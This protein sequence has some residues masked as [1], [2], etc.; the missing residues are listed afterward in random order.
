MLSSLLSHITFYQLLSQFFSKWRDK[1]YCGYLHLF[2]LTLPLSLSM[3][4][5]VYKC[6]VFMLK[7]YF[8]RDL[9]ALSLNMIS[10]TTNVLLG[11]LILGNSGE[12]V[13]NYGFS[14]A[15]RRRLNRQG[16]QQFPA[17]RRQDQVTLL[18]YVN[19]NSIWKLSAVFGQGPSRDIVQEKRMNL[20]HSGLEAIP[21]LTLSSIRIY[22]ITLFSLIF[23]LFPSFSWFILL[24]LCSSPLELTACF[25]AVSL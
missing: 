13:A 22:S 11:N 20:E 12:L 4:Q 24:K 9:R 5:Y 17:R 7:N 6:C 10:A 3:S 18:L 19:I 14:V 1:D 25:L 2:S 16:N 8:L 15:P 23:C 21:F